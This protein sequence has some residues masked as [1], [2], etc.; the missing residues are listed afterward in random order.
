LDRAVFFDRDGTL[1]V[2]IGY[3]AHPSLVVPYSRT[4]EA[5]RLAREADFRLVAVTNQSGVARGYLTEGDLEGIHDRM[6]EVFRAGGA[7]L[8]AVYYCP[9]HPEGTVA[10]Y[11]RTC[12]CRK[13]SPG[14]GTMAARS[15]GI[16]LKKSFMIGDK[17]TDLL[18][19]RAIGAISCLVRTGFGSVEE[20]RL[21][22]GRLRPYHVFDDVLGAVDWI[23]RQGQVQ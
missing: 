19:G 11:A 2:E 17:E 16:D 8:D 10:G 7:Q 21:G 4:L 3:L 13:P 18:F 5:L 22:E 12:D 14:M 15:L 6:Q 23:V 1:L 20:Q 9:H